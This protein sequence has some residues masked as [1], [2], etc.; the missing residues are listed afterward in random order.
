MEKESA[1]SNRNMG[2]EKHN[3]QDEERNT[4]CVTFSLYR[5]CRAIEELQKLLPA[6]CWVD[7]HTLSPTDVIT[8]SETA[9]QPMIGKIRN[10]DL[11]GHSVLWSGLHG[12]G[13]PSLLLP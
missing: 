4:L 8:I 10:G 11:N 7:Y 1:P 13:R 6:K 2:Q 3:F 9:Q 5:F 12:L